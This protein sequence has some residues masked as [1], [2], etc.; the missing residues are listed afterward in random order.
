M[1]SVDRLF[2]FDA[3]TQLMTE[4][5]WQ[6]LWRLV[7]GDGVY[8]ESS[9]SLAVRPNS[10]PSMSVV[11]QP[12]AAWVGGAYAEITTPKTLSIA[13]APS[14]GTRMDRVVL[15]RNNATNS[16]HVAVVQGVPSTSPSPPSLTRAGDI[17][18]I[19]LATVVVP[20]GT[21]AIGPSNIIDE[22]GSPTFC[23]YQAPGTA[24]DW[25]HA[26]LA[27]SLPT[28]PGNYVE[29]CQLQSNRPAVVIVATPTMQA[30]AKGYA[31]VTPSGSG[32]WDVP[33]AWAANFNATIDDFVLE[34]A[35]DSGA[36]R[37]VLRLRRRVGTTAASAFVSVF[38]L[39]EV[40]P[41]SGTG[42]STQDNPL[43]PRAQRGWQLLGRAVTSNNA[44]AVS[45]TGL[46][47][48]RDG[49]LR[50]VL[51]GRNALSSDTS[52]FLRVN[53]EPDDSA[54]ACN[55]LSVGPGTSTVA[56]S[57]TGAHVGWAGANHNVF[58]EADIGF[59]VGQLQVRSRSVAADRGF[60][61][62]SR[63]TAVLLE[64]TRVDLIAST[65]G[66]IGSD[67]VIELYQLLER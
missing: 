34:A 38:H 24:Q 18:E 37:P 58:A 51:R 52:Y 67:S 47:M 8:M 6:R 66:G 33:P 12:G 43:W 59:G 28:T 35:W 10:P 53:G 2:G 55:V 25:T 11:V 19:S 65:P 13:A 17:Y 46:R 1:V 48:T 26:T 54:W 60:I 50:L 39:S 22:R 21:T 30:A 64:V 42:T 15:R 14:S 3:P 23:G 49:M 57:A 9:S 63:R 41:R 40:T 7:A 5:L 36:S 27:V 61:S 20:A 16:I 45:V 62:W 29:V 44:V 56:V 32:L 31:F 4:A